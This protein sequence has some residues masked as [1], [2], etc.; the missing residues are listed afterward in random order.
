MKS[1]SASEIVQLRQV[2][3]ERF[4]NVRAWTEET[5]AKAHSF[6]PTGLL[7]L[8]KLLNGGLPRGVVTEIV[9]EKTGTG[10]AVL[11][12]L[13]LRQ[14]QHKAHPVGLIDGQDSFDA[15]TVQP[16]VLSQLLWVRCRTADEAIKATDILLRDH[17]L[18]LV[19]LDLKMN[20]AHQ[21]R[22]IS[23]MAWYRLQR[24]L[25][26]T[27]TAFVVIT[28]FPIAVSADVRIHLAS[29]FALAALARNE[30]EIL[31]ELK[32]DLTRWSSGQHTEPIA[33]QAG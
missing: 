23:A 9:A 31:P 19:A 11:L 29:Q 1:N 17:N 28:P 13:L 25:R 24:I 22:K 12:R 2:L 33:A 18:P 20:P 15:A 14:S 6:W 21:L 27:A 4:P 10:S 32:F 7:H 5:A 26:Q 16:S 3:S 8:D 30:N